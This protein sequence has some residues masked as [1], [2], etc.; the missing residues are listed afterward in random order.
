MDNHALNQKPGTEVEWTSEL[1][2]EFARCEEDPIYFAENY[3]WIVSKD[4]GRIKLPCYDYQKEIITSIYDNSEIVVECARQAGKALPLETMI[5]TPFGWKSMAQLKTGDLVFDEK[6]KPTKIIAT[7]K[8]FYNHDCYRITFDDGSSVVADAEHLWTVKHASS[9]K[10][11][12][13]NLTTQELYE[14]VPVYKDSRGKDV[15][16]W[17]IPLCGTVQYEKKP[18]AIDPYTLGLWL[19]D[20]ESASGRICGLPEDISFYKPLLEGELSHNHSPSKNLFTAT[21]YGLSEKLRKLKL[22]DKKHIPSQY[23]INDEKV[24]LELLRGLMDTDGYVEKS[25]QNGICFSAK[26]PRLI[27]DVYQLLTSL[28]LKVFRKSKPSHNAEILFFHCPKEKFEVFKLPRKLK[29]QIETSQRG[30]YTSHRYIRKIE[31]VE[32]VPTKCIAVEN[33]SHLFLC[34]EHFIPTHNTTALTAFIIHYIIFNPDKTVAIL[35]NK[36]NTAKEILRRIKFAYQLLP[37]WIKHAPVKWNETEVFLENGSSI[38]AAATSNDNIRGFSIDVCFIDE[39]AFIDNWETFYTAL[40]NTLSSS[41][42]RKTKMVLVSTVNGLNHFYE[43]TSQAR[44]GQNDFKLISVTWRDVPGRDEN[45]KK[46]T[47]RGLNNNLQMFAQEHENEYLGSSGTLISGAKLKQLA[48]TYETPIFEELGVR[49]YKVPHPDHAYVAIVDVS[50]GKQLDYST[51]QVID[52]TTMPYQQVMTYSSNTIVPSDFADIINRI[53]RTYNEAFLLI[54]LNDMG[55]SVAEMMF[56]DYEYENML[57]S[58]NKGRLGKRILT[59]FGV[60][61]NADR[62]VRTTMPVKR[63]GCSLIKLLIEQNELEIVDLPTISEFSTFSKKNNSYEAEKGKHDDL[64]MPLVLFG[65][66]TDQPFFKE[67]TEIQT[68]LSIREHMEREKESLTGPLIQS[69]EV[70]DKF[71]QVEK[72]G[73]DL[74]T[75]VDNVYPY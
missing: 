72:R 59:A 73:D 41:V 9:R 30:E 74:W 36:E 61:P 60:T 3:F 43:I 75:T 69:S 51:V 32:S 57:S 37:K 21:I 58:E 25:G 29:K 64:V 6:G 56:N 47:I 4:K 24:R 50:H 34:S 31:K 53:G 39:A 71:P 65:W 35:A 1:I 54:E 2:H 62:G 23:L 42:E 38:I 52:I 13:T 16:K 70:L 12:F 68:V 46:R 55:Q 66:L 19:G 18:T 44:K 20:G 8:V 11:G 49:Q 63:L 26:N 28:G 7:S 40:Y 33:D 67:L 5:P 10:K 27:N 45:W 17:K 22:I 15:S 48:E 14:S